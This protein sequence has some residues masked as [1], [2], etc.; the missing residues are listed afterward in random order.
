MV[1]PEKRLEELETWLVDAN[2]QIEYWRDMKRFI[3]SQKQ[4]WLGKLA[5]VQ[6]NE[7]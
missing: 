4:L 6:N 5:M 3:E 2:E 1:D 7:E